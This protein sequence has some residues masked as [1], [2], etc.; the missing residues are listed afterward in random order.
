MQALIGNFVMRSLAMQRAT[1]ICNK[2]E[3]R[4]VRLK[5]GL[6]QGDA[7]SLLLFVITIEPLSRRLNDVYEKAMM[8]EFGTNHLMF[9]DDTKL[10][11]KDRTTSE[12]MN[13]TT[14]I[15]INVYVG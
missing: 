4:S 3:I 8:G 7:I 5:N 15:C 1:L 6:L 9:I 14:C 13:E 2:E 11:T 10:M 12:A